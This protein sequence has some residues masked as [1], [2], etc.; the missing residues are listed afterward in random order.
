MVE[1]DG[2]H[3]IVIDVST[4]VIRIIPIEI[5]DYF[6]NGKMVTGAKLTNMEVAMEAGLGFEC[7]HS[8]ITKCEFN[9]SS[10]QNS[11]LI[12]QEYSLQHDAH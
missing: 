4:N 6:V 5:G 11:S 12:L 7:A 3:G 2:K 1:L 8:F 10:H 9:Q